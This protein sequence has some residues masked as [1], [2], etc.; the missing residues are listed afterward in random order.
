MYIKYLIPGLLGCVLLLHVP[1]IS[2][3]EGDTEEATTTSSK[4]DDPDLLIQTLTAYDQKQVDDAQK[5]L[6]DAQQ[7]LQDAQ[8]SGTATD[9]ELQ[10]L[11]DAVDQ[12]QTDLDSAQQTA[13]DETQAITDEVGQLTDDQVT[14]MN[15][16][17]NN[18]VNSGL[19]VNITSEDLQTV[20]DGNYNF[21][22]ISMFTKSF[23]EEAKFNNLADKFTEKGMDKQATMMQERAQTQKQRFEDKIGKFDTTGAAKGEAV[24]AAKQAAK[25]EAKNEAKNQ[26]KNDAKGSAIAAAK[27][28]AKDA[29]KDA[30][31][32]AAKNQAK[33]NAKDNAK[34][35]AK[36]IVKEEGKNA[37]KG[38]GQGH[39][40]GKPEGS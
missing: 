1:M 13:D 39:G 35:I 27:Q 4:F 32:E 25:D 18:A 24:S 28:A 34:D 30:A 15:Q 38:Q 10:S 5:T 9:D 17:L 21:Q 20:I 22:Q 12:A 33:D 29:A 31:K 2:A 36:Q 16:K 14:A 37:A 6:D 11:Q 3:A 7:A 19:L 23:E 26:A 8:D 40:K